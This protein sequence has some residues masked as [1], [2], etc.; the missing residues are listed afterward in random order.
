MKIKTKAR[1]KIKIRYKEKIEP[2]R[3]RV[4]NFISFLLGFSGSLLTY[5]ISTYF[6]ESSG[7]E[8]IGIFYFVGYFFILLF[9]LNMHKLIK[10][11][12]GVF[13][14]HIS[15]LANIIFVLAM[16][17]VGKSFLGILFMILYLVSISVAWTSLD[18]VLEIFSADKMSG[19]IR[20]MHLTVF[21][22]GY[23]LG[24]FL[25]SRLLVEFDFAG[26]FFSVGILSIFIFVVS[27]FG[28]HGTKNHFHPRKL[29]SIRDLIF[30]SLRK[31]NIAKIYYISLILDFFYA[32]MVVYAP[33][34][35]LDL[36][37]SWEQIG[38]AFTIMLVPFV[39]VQYPA[40][41][42]ADKKIGEK[43]LIVMAILIMGLS[44]FLFFYGSSEDIF[45]WAVILFATRVGAA[46]IEI[47]RDSYFYKQIDGSEADLIDFFR[48]SSSV[49]YVAAAVFSS[50]ILWILPLK[51][52]FLFLSLII[53]SALW[54]ALKLA[55]SD[56]IESPQL[57][58]K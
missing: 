45:I 13:V 20:G 55:D 52:V 56:L 33:I 44:T 6:K 46:L 37:F 29:K 38:V 53:F 1:K 15:L 27:L 18:G 54:P 32:L 19:R 49:G 12:S 22:A 16:M 42:L 30:H 58:E 4:I 8:N 5:V 3:L 10:R 36:G 7:M 39:L 57:T 14:F 43:E 21:N 47:L 41:V 31:K 40:G 25:A 48:T 34:Y 24:P 26:I 28:L 2:G 23:I 50:L 11:T 17:F 9:L 35:L 51:F